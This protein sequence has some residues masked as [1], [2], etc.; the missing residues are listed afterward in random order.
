MQLL[1]KK[2]TLTFK[3]YLSHKKLSSL[4]SHAF[5]LPKYPSTGISQLFLSFKKT[6]LLPIQKKL[7]SLPLHYQDSFLPQRKRKPFHQQQP[8]EPPPKK[9]KATEKENAVAFA[10]QKFFPS[11]YL[12]SLLVHCVELEYYWEEGIF[13][14]SHAF[15]WLRS[16]LAGVGVRF[17]EKKG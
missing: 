9:A 5:F 13:F 12:P 14:L 6:H 10:T 17:K 11:L 4:Q 7:L 8:K 3:Q 16:V 15:Y 1:P 2:S